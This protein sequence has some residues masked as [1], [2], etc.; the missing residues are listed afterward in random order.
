MHTFLSSDIF[1]YLSLVLLLREFWIGVFREYEGDANG[2][3]GHQRR[4]SAV[5]DAHSE[6]VEA[7]RVE[8][9]EPGYEDE[10]SGAVDAKHTTSVS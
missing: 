1:I 6:G 3:R 4:K 5:G 10:A 9:Q 2:G 7:H 8:V